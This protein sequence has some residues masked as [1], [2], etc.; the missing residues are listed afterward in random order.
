MGKDLNVGNPS[1][2]S[3][4]RP[5]YKPERPTPEIPI[6]DFLEAQRDPQVKRFL[7]E[8]RAQGE[9][10]EQEGKIHLSRS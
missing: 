1:D 8:A 5:H 2:T 4:G 6:S 9:K 3:P 7:Q 10:L